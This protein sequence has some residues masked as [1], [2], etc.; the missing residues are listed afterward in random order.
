M[1]RL[2]AEV[3]VIGKEDPF[4]DADRIIVPGTGS[5]KSFVNALREMSAFQQVEEAVVN[6]GTPIL[7]ICVGAQ[8]FLQRGTEDG[9]SFGLGWIPGEVVEISRTSSEILIPHVG[10]QETL[11]L[12]PTDVLTTYK[13]NATYYYTHSFKMILEDQRS[14]LAVCDYGQSIT[15]VYRHKNIIG[16]QFHPEKSHNDG[17]ELLKWFLER[18]FEK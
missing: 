15:A 18:R 10:W 16:V 3:H 17:I 5:F 9:R 4:N 14:V 13:P 1:S 7:G 11:F 8:A 2:G 12:H 6:Q